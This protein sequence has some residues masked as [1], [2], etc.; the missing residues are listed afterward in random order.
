M[1]AAT[2]ARSRGMPETAAVAI[3]ALTR[4]NPTQKNTSD[5][6]S[7]VKD[8]VELRRTSIRLLANNMVS[9]TTS[10]PRELRRPTMRPENGGRSIAMMAMGRMSIPACMAESSR[11]FCR[12]RV[13]RNKKSLG[14]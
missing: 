14:P 4:P 3:G 9:A 11:T 12:K 8:V 10:G 7:Q 13:L 6:K 2:P 5:K 1:P